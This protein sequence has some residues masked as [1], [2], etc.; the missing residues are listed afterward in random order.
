MKKPEVFPGSRSDIFLCLMTNHESYKPVKLLP[1]IS[2]NIDPPCF[3]KD[4]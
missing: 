1:N 4:P 3:L 2:W